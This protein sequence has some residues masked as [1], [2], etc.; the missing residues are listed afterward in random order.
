M[1]RGR[2]PQGLRIGV[3]RGVCAS[4]AADRRIGC[5]RVLRVKRE[6]PQLVRRVCG[7][8]VG[9]PIRLL[10]TAAIR[11]GTDDSIKGVP[12]EAVSCDART[13]G[14]HAAAA[15]ARRW[16]GVFRSVSD[17]TD[18]FRATTRWRPTVPWSDNA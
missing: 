5:D 15:T 12:L 3:F 10:R 1:R 9:L 14:D 7:E 2:C 11:R 18:S 13:I 16:A 6:Q 17:G 8:P 4:S